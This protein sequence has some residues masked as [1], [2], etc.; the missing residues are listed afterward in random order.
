MSASDIRLG[1]VVADLVE[2]VVRLLHVA[3]AF[4]DRLA[5]GLVRIELR[6]LRQVADLDARAGRGLALDILVHAGHDLQQRRFAGAV[7]AQ[8]ADL[9]AG[10]ETHSEMSRQDLRLGGSENYTSPAC[11]RRRAVDDQQVRRRLS[12]Q[13]LLRRLRVCR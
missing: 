3:D 5:H 10:E 9:R 4:L 2:A 12:G 7:Q 11:W 6:F 13:A 8:H 1:N